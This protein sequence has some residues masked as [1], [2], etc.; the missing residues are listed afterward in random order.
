LVVEDDVLEALLAS[1]HRGE[2]DPIVI[3][4]RF[5]A[6]DRDPIA[7]RVALENFLHRTASGHAVA[8]D[9]QPLARIGRAVR[10]FAILWNS[11]KIHSRR[12]GH[13][14]SRL[15]RALR[16]VGGGIAFGLGFAGAL[17]ILRRWRGEA[18][19]RTPL[20]EA[21]YA[22]RADSLQAK[23]VQCSNIL[24]SISRGGGPA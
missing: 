8:D 15:D 4:P 22:P 6:E 1:E 7:R 16:L 20:S 12:S 3:D 21:A 9:D 17:R 19:S 10:H 23:I 18:M 14:K 13:E 5:R 2:H 24:P 11:T